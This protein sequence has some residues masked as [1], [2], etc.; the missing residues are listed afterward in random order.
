VWI[1]REK[2]GSGLLEIASRCVFPEHHA[3]SDSAFSER[4][5]RGHVIPVARQENSHVAATKGQTEPSSGVIRETGPDDALLARRSA[6]ESPLRQ[7][8]EP[9][10]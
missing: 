5:Q 1:E 9:E 4:L 3:R 2:L 8:D 6:T 7:E 10:E